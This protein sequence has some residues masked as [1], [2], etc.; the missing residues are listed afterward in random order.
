MAGVAQSGVQGATERHP[1]ARVVVLTTFSAEHSV[2]EALRAG[3]CGYLLK[4]TPRERLVH[5]VHAAARGEAPISPELSAFITARFTA[6]PEP[7]ANGRPAALA[8][9]SERELDVLRLLA[10]GRSNAEIA[11]QLHIGQATVKTHLANLLA[12]LPARDRVQ[13][14][15]AAYETGLIRPGEH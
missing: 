8:E 15:I 11:A 14:V 4:D 10:T 7:V 12:K 3:A 6:A 13:A 9:L 5:A 1:R 2:W